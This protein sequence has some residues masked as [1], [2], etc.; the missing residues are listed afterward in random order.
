VDHNTVGTGYLRAM[1]LPILA[2]RDFSSHD[3]AES[4]KVAII[5]ETFARVFFAG[6]SPLGRTFDIAEG[7]KNLQVIGVVRDAKYVSLQEKQHAAAFYPYVQHPGFLENLAIRYS[8]DP[9]SA[10]AGIRRA[11][12]EVD[13][14]LPIGGFIALSR[15]V[16]DS[17]QNRRI[18]AQLCTVFAIL[19]A[20]LASIGIYG[21]MS[22]GIARRT[23]E[24]GLRMALGAVRSD[25]LW[26]CAT[27][28]RC[29]PSGLAPAWRSPSAAAVLWNR[30][31]T[32]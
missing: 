26:C 13:P 11:V 32:T 31:S 5:N 7:T 9:K 6:V 10:I 16:D 8:G 21:V 19:A 30:W 29:W 15:M 22:Y 27:P 17:V 12:A 20:I 1:G 2:G 28:L 3:T 24:F 25:V 4:P 23:S 18:V 14:N